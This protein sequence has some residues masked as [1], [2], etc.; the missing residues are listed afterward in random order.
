[1]I[2]RMK[3]DEFERVFG[4]F[5]E[6][7]RNSEMLTDI[8]EELETRQRLAPGRIAPVFSLAQRDGQM[9]SLADLR[10]KVVLVDFWAK[11]VWSVSC[12]FPLDEGVLQEVSRQRVEILGVGVDKDVKAWEKALDAENYHGCMYRMRKFGWKAYGK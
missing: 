10:G 1:M 7:V 8:R 4:L 11:L 3:L 5:D 2:D 12:V 6:A 9:L